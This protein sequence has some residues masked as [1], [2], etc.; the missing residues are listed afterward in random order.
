VIGRSVHDIENIRHL[1]H[2]TGY[3]RRGPVLSNAIP[4]I[5]MALWDIKGSL[6]GMPL[7]DLFG[8][9]CRT[10]ARPYVHA[11]GR[12]AAEFEERARSPVE[13]G[14]TLATVGWRH[15]GIVAG[16]ERPMRRYQPAAAVAPQLPEHGP[17]TAANPANGAVKTSALSLPEARAVA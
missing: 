15:Q 2:L 11:S 4:G 12:D 17:A 7:Y 16:A 13:Q 6:A 9:R 1:L 10:V 5:D 8:G 3:L 14:F